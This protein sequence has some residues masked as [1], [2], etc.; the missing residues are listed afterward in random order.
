MRTTENTT[1]NYHNEFGI[2]DR[3]YCCGK[4]KKIIRITENVLYK[5]S[6]HMDIQGKV[7]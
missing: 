7:V 6:K 4:R 3:R 1:N 5:N 2:V